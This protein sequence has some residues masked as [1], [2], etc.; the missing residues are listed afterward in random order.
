VETER[1]F[2]LANQVELHVRNGNGEVYLGGGT[3]AARAWGMYRPARVVK[4]VRGST[5]RAESRG[6]LEQRDM[7]PPSATRS[8]G[9]AGPRRLRR[10]AEPL[11][12]ED[13]SLNTPRR[14]GPVPPVGAGV[15]S[16]GQTAAVVATDRTP[17]GPDDE[18]RHRHHGPDDEGVEHRREHRVDQPGEHL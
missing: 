11:T 1:R 9:S 18:H 2:Y 15:G 17:G 6:E 16:A 12:A 7:P 14:R 5:S 8:G 13:I 4:Q 10:T 3:R